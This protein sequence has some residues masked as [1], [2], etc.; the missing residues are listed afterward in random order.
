[1]RREGWVLED[2]KWY[3]VLNYCELK[4]AVVQ[5]LYV[6]KCSKCGKVWHKFK[7]PYGCFSDSVI[8]LN[9]LKWV[10]EPE[11]L[12]ILYAPIEVV[13]VPKYAEV[14][15]N[16]EK[17][18]FIMDDPTSIIIT[19][20]EITEAKIDISKATPTLCTKCIMEWL[21]EN[22]P[23]Y[24]QGHLLIYEDKEHELTNV[25]SIIDDGKN[26]TDELFNHEFKNFRVVTREFS[27]GVVA[28]TYS[29][30]CN[31]QELVIESR[32]HP[33]VRVPI[34]SYVFYHPHPEFD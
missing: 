1:M 30:D 24:R 29:I 17:A 34:G 2:G 10:I 18:V 7:N 4:T 13:T 22:E 31:A 26:V 33:E 20:D 8:P 25:I 9:A 11:N 12:L 19:A 27:W 15:V 5:K 16:E 23:K 14:E 21:R 28:R 6:N 32:D 3:P